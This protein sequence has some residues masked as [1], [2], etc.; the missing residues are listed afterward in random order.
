MRAEHES[1][2]VDIIQY[3]V[4]NIIKIH[5]CKKHCFTNGDKSFCSMSDYDII[6]EPLKSNGYHNTESL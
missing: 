3:Y 5:C 4:F 2:I 1:R 6:K